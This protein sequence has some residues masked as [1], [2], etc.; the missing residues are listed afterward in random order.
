FS[1]LDPVVRATSGAFLLDGAGVDAL[2]ELI[3]LVTL[4]TPNADESAILVGP[5]APSTP[6]E[7]RAQAA[8]LRASGARN[9]LLKGGHVGNDR[10][11]VDVLAGEHGATELT[12]E[13]V[14]VS[15]T[16]GTGCR[17]SSAIAAHVALGASLP[18]ACAAA[19]Q[20]VARWIADGNGA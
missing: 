4:V 18:E 5:P 15:R 13:R 19:Q 9:V 14:P 11:V 8:K 12:V 6:A 10:L 7:S 2:R 16:H 3:Q 17:L 1:V 20:F